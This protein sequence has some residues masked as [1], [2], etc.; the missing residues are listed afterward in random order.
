[1]LENL[2]KKK[3][4]SED[5]VSNQLENNSYCKQNIHIVYDWRKYTFNRTIIQE[6]YEQF[7][8]THTI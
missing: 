1:M 7:N 3:L 4:M 6:W 5:E 2:F 8:F